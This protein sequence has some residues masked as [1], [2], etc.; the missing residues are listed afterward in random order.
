MA[1]AT[2]AVGLRLVE[3]QMIHTGVSWVVDVAI[4]APRVAKIEL[5]CL[6]SFY[7]YLLLL[8]SL[9]IHK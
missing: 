2:S 4:L 7:I 1:R 9:F 5:A 3:A 8:H 6:R